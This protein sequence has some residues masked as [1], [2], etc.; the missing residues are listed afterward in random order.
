MTNT[1]LHIR[2]ELK[3][4]IVKPEIQ[5]Y[6]IYM[7]VAV[8]FSELAETQKSINTRDVNSLSHI[9]IVNADGVYL[10]CYSALLF[11]LKLIHSGWYKDSSTD[12]PVSQVFTFII[13]NPLLKFTCLDTRSL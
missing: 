4:L 13:F 1:N 5:I 11:N 12:I 10:A 3:L 6:L 2:W 7:S 9:A 8:F